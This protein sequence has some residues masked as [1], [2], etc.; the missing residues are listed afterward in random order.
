[1]NSVFRQMR[2]LWRA[3]VLWVALAAGALGIAPAAKAEEPATLMDYSVAIVSDYVFRGAD[4]FESAWT[5]REE[6]ESMV[7][8]APALQPSVSFYSASGLWFNFWGSFALT[9]RDSDEKTEFDGLKTL[10]ELDTTIGYDWSNR[11]GSF[12]AGIVNY[13]YLYPGAQGEA[14]GTIQEMFFKWGLPVLES[15]APTLSH[16]V[17]SS[18]ANSYTAVSVG[19]GEALSW[20]VNM[21]YGSKFGAQGVQDVTATIAYDLGGGL[22]VNG[23][24]AYR[25][26]PKLHG[27]SGDG[28]YASAKDGKEADYPP[29]I[30][31]VGVSWGGAVTE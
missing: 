15:L 2:V 6:D 26:S 30:V 22:A 28:K 17:D 19:G 12:T 18:T 20:G 11:L 25:P 27:Y 29:A 31:W 16:Y 24:A 7:N 14:G 10:D 1:M 13:A 21:G 9:E 23:N 5:K 8:L 4:V 3:I